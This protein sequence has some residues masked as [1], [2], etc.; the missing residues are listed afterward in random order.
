MFNIGAAKIKQVY[1][2]LNII[3]LLVIIGA[4]ASMFFIGLNLQVVCIF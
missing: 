2:Y 3:L 1:K 4:F